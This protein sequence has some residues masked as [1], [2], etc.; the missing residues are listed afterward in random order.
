M[1]CQPDSMTGDNRANEGQKGKVEDKFKKPNEPVR[2]QA[3]SLKPIHVLL[4]RSVNGF[5]SYAV[6]NFRKS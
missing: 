4:K 2:H 3:G 1:P 6:N 5:V